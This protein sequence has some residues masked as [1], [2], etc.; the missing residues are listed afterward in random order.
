MLVRCGFGNEYSTKIELTH[1][2]ISIYAFAVVTRMRHSEGVEYTEEWHNE[3]R[4]IPH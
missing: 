3:K 4:Y 1:P 2:L